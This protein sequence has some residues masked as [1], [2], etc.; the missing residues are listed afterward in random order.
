[1][2]RRSCNWTADLLVRSEWMCAPGGA[3]SGGL[4][5]RVYPF[6][7]LALRRGADLLRG[8]FAVLEQHQRRD[9]TNAELAGNGGIF[10]DV[11]L[12]DLDLPLHLGRNLLE[13]GCNHPARSAP[14]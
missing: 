7:Q 11:Q 14:F 6:H 2:A 4:N 1:M 8:E 5:R 3:R 9:R 13:R 10:V 12:G